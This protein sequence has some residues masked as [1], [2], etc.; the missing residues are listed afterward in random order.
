MGARQSSNG[1]SGRSTR[2]R[3]AARRASAPRASRGSARRG[4]SP[5][6]AR[7]PRSAGTWSSPASAAEFERDVPFGVWADALDAYV[8]SQDAR[9]WTAG[10]ADA[11]RRARRRS[12]RRLRQPA[13]EPATRRRRRAL[14]RAPRDPHAAR[15]ARGRPAAR[16]RARRPALER[17]RVDRAD[18]G[19]CC[20]AARVRRSCSRSPSGPARRP[21]AC[22]PRSPCRRVSRIELQQ[23]SEAQAQELLGDVEPARGRGDLPATAAATRSTSS[24]SRA[25]A[26]TRGAGRRR[27]QR[28]ARAGVPRRS[29]RRWPRS[30]SRC[31]HAARALLDGAAVAGEPFEPDLAAAIAELP[32]PRALAA[33][34]ELLGAR[35]RAPHPGA[36]AL[37]LPPPARAPRGRTSPRRAAG[38]S[39]PT[40]ARRRRSP[41]AAPRRPSARTTS[42]SPRAR[43]TRRRSRCC[44]R[45]ARRRG[46]AGAGRGRALV[47]G[48]AAAAAR[49]ATTSARW[50]CGWRSP[51]R[52][53]RSASSSAAATTLLEA[54]DLL[55]ADAVARRVELTARCAAVEHWLGRHEEAHAVS[56]ARGR[57]FPTAGTPEAAALQIELAVDGLY[58]LDFEQTLRRWAAA[59]LEA[60]RRARRPRA[61]RGG[62]VGAVR[63]AR[64]AAGAIAPA[65][66]HRDE[67]LAHD[68]A[69]VRRRAGAAPRGALLPRL[70][71]ELPRAL[72]RRDRARRPRHRDRARHRRGTA[73]RSR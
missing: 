73:A 43:A 42:S 35:P 4:C 24:S 64:S 26:R 66:E 69:A 15:A 21:S 38:G 41:R 47:R 36:A 29:R 22:P 25:P 19:A 34:D 33:L 61:D 20:G 1:S 68:R 52:C 18:R 17:R 12:C 51:R 46:A 44:S 27:R 2:W 54:L 48:G 10:D 56:C 14:P 57:S 70:G 53:A 13:G 7:A 30:S 58:E 28:R 40:R 50:T 23:L 32:A 39:R 3:T 45:R 62:G 71:G 49:R 37:R 63:S 65:R 16:A 6:C 55:P 72:R 9:A 60:A 5:S 11:A 8:A 31:R 59:A 67:A